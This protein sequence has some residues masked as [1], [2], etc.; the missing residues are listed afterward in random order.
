MMPT[1]SQAPKG[2]KEKDMIEKAIMVPETCPDL[3]PFTKERKAKAKQS[4]DATPDSKTLSYD[5]TSSPKSKK[6]KN[7]E[8]TEYFSSP[9]SFIRMKQ[10]TNSAS[11]LTTPDRDF[12][13]MLIQESYK[14]FDS[15]N[16]NTVK[17]LIDTAKKKGKS[18][19]VY[20]F[21]S[22]HCC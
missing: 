15:S 1:R 3:W 9:P 20:S 12:I 8:L 5:M 10:K 19:V 6:N 16:A 14:L 18:F 4:K 21:Y 11:V 17:E 2:S 13:H 22:S 7:M